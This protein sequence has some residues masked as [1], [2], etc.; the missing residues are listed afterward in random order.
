MAKSKY[1][2]TTKNIFVF[3]SDIKLQIK[4]YVTVILLDVLYVCETWTLTFREEH[5]LRVF[6]KSV[7][8]DIWT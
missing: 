3:P 8:E 1:V 5:R 2:G 4:I 7:E 6:E